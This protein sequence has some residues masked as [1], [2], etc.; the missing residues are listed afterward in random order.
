MIVTECD[1]PLVPVAELPYDDDR[2]YSMTDVPLMDVDQVMVT[3]VEV[4]AVTVTDEMTMPGM[5][6]ESSL[7]AISDGSELD[8]D[9]ALK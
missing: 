3:E 2:P 5:K 1:V 6:V 4:A 8:T 7:Y 9:L